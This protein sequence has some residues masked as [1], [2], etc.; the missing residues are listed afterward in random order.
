MSEQ[1]DQDNIPSFSE[2]SSEHTEHPP[3]FSAASSHLQA[4]QRCS[5]QDAP[6]N[7][8]QLSSADRLLA[9]LKAQFG[10][11]EASLPAEASAEDLLAALHDPD[12][13]KRTAAVRRLGKMQAP[14]ALESL[15]TLVT[16]DPEGPVR[17]AAARALG[18]MQ[19]LSAEKA[20][21]DALKHRDEDVRIAAAQALG[22][23]SQSISEESIQRVIEC[24]FCE[25]EESVRAALIAA[26]GRL[27][28]RT[29]LDALEAA[30]QD[31]EWIVREAAASA[32]GQ[33]GERADREALEALLDDESLSVCQAAILAL[34]KLVQA[35][36][37][38][39]IS[40]ETDGQTQEA[41]QESAP[42]EFPTQGAG[43]EGDPPPGKDARPASAA[44]PEEMQI[45]LPPG[46]DEKREQNQKGVIGDIEFIKLVPFSLRNSLPAISQAFDDQW[47]PNTLLNAI[48]HGKISYRDAR[49]YLYYLA[50]TEYM[51]SLLNS[52]RVIINRTFL[53]N[54]SWLARDYFPGS[55]TREAFKKLLREGVIVPFLYTETDPVQ[56]L[57]WLKPQEENF[58]AWVQICKET[59]VQCM[60]F[61]WENEQNQ[62]RAQNQLAFS[63]HNFATTAYARETE[64]FLRDL[65]LGSSPEQERAFARRLED[66]QA[67]SF[68]YFQEHNRQHVVRTFLYEQFIT[69][70]N[71][72]LRAYDSSKPFAGAIKQLLDLAYNSS[73]ADELDCHLITP[74]D[75]PTRLVLQDWSRMK[76]GIPTMQASDLIEMLSKDTFQIIQKVLEREGLKSMSALNL[77]DI[78]ELRRSDEWQDYITRLRSLLNQPLRFKEL[79]GSVATSY[80]ALTDQI[81]RRVGERNLRGGGSL[82][83]PW[84]PA[85]EVTLTIGGLD[86]VFLWSSEGIYST[87]GDKQWVAEMRN[88]IQV[89][90]TSG[91]TMCNLRFTITDGQRKARRAKLSSRLEILQGRLENARE[92]WEE[93]VRTLG[94]SLK[95]QEFASEPEGTA[96]I[97]QTGLPV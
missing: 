23:M 68:H 95:A 59:V 80:I 3:T 86:T 73:L 27:G 35:E 82:T 7:E 20:L 45:Q 48:F 12:W 69:A 92:Q 93:V 63:F 29:P 67:A 60:R 90:P 40:P 87:I 37:E 81:T 8:K 65:G 16:S 47:V 15:I 78:L 38:Q 49:H 10:M 55:P 9:N 50:R 53:Y 77:W 72:S 58:A 64:R 97:N 71:P 39:L 61:S 34:T 84:K 76:Q 96:T 88:R 25:D 79:A 26:L 30:L 83:A 24:F 66:L 31:D 70:G 41:Q 19:A 44:V 21:T 11:A 52:E 74:A 17:A 13:A 2:T 94:E 56:R 22:A 57:L 43:E 6:A 32:M 14:E 75:S 36:E 91:S 85:I 5:L 89:D 46:E 62:K 51:R 28:E 4:D 54:S 42:P 33:Q 1:F 18:E